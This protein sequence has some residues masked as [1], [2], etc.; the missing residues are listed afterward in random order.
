M[1]CGPVLLACSTSPDGSTWTDVSSGAGTSGTTTIDLPTLTARYVRVISTSSDDTY[2]WT[3]AQF[4]AYTR[5]PCPEE[6]ALE[7]LTDGGGDVITTGVQGRLVMPFNAVI[8]AVE[9]LADQYGSIE[10]DIWKSDYAGYPPSSA[11]TI[12]ASTPP[13]ISTAQKSQ[14]TTLAGWTTTLNR[15]DCLVYNV[16]SASAVQQVSVVLLVTRS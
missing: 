15:G 8:T 2:W 6:A 16:V 3:I 14:D 11:D 12:C 9:L 5:G 1:S 13:T 10:V 7:F 4:N